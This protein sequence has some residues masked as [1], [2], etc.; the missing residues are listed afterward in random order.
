MLALR[1]TVISQDGVGRVQT[2]TGGAGVRLCGDG[3]CDQAT[4]GAAGWEE[5]DG[6]RADLVRH[7]TTGCARRSRG[8]APGSLTA[9]SRA[10]PLGFSTPTLNCP[11][12]PLM[13]AVHIA[14]TLP[15]IIRGWRRAM[16]NWKSDLDALI[17]DTMAFAAQVAGSISRVPVVQSLPAQVPPLPA[18]ATPATSSPDREGQPNSWIKS[19]REEI[20]R[21][22]A[23]FRAHQ[24]RWIREREDYANSVLKKIA[25]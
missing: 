4:C 14:P 19:E 8:R 25:R 16:G 21:K 20:A 3:H 6:T 15:S 17:S 23:N 7:A 2:W 12:G 22:V 5:R 11:Q 13:T 1:P 24:E 9:H 10:R 18:M